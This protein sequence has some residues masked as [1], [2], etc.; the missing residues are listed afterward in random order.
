MFWFLIIKFTTFH[1]IQ[2]K[3]RPLQT[4]Q[5]VKTQ[6]VLLFKENFNLNTINEIIRTRVF[7]NKDFDPKHFIDMT[8]VTEM[9]DLPKIHLKFISLLSIVLESK[10]NS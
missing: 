10:V 4:N 6:H 8:I 1:E 3:R 9:M 5:S 7:I 2:S